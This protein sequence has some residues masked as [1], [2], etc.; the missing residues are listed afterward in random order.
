MRPI[1]RWQLVAEA[2]SYTPELTALAIVYS[3][4][5]RRPGGVRTPIDPNQCLYDEVCVTSTVTVL[6]TYYGFISG[7]G[8]YGVISIPGT[9]TLIYLSSVIPS[10]KV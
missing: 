10:S 2:I 1:T 6:F 8:G 3:L 9:S 5:F 7:S 4:Y